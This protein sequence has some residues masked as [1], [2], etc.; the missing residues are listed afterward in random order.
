[1]RKTLISELEHQHKH[2]ATADNMI[3]QDPR[4]YELYIIVSSTLFLIRKCKIMLNLF[5]LKNV[6]FSKKIKIVDLFSPQSTF[7]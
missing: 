1:M 3:A 4:N 5:L 2:A 7:C 6:L